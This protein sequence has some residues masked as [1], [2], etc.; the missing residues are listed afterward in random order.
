MNKERDS[1][2]LGI[3]IC[4]SK[5]H[6]SNSALL[7]VTRFN[8]GHIN[9]L[10]AWS[11]NPIFAVESSIPRPHIGFCR[12]QTCP[13][14]SSDN[15]LLNWPDKLTVLRLV[16][17]DTKAK[18]KADMMLCFYWG[19]PVHNIISFISKNR[20]MWEIV[21]NNIFEDRQR[22]DI[23][24][25]IQGLYIPFPVVKSQPQCSQSHFSRT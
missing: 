11:A 3:S 13:C 19:L 5:V 16:A 8:E 21:S 18:N 20:H 6:N 17:W 9:I 14:H 25:P 22:R 24:F 10:T 1:L 12:A 23:P 2:L 4:S 15:K 7:G